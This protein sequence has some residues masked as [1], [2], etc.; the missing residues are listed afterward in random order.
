MVQR[1][2][3]GTMLFWQGFLQVGV[4]V[5]LQQMLGILIGF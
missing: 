5:D 4:F 3:S 2:F 1:H